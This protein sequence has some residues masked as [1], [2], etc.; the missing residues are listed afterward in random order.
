MDSSFAV[1][2]QQM[3]ML[4]HDHVAGDDKL[5]ALAHLLQHRQNKVATTRRCRAMA[6]VDNNCK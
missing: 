3:N 5:I 2:N 1:A 4:G 6:A